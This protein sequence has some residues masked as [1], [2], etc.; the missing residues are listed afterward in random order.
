MS[1]RRIEALVDGLIHLLGSA[2]NPDSELHQIRNC[3]GLMN[4]SRPGKCQIDLKGR[5]VFDSWLASYRASCY[6]IGL[7][8][9]GESRAGLKPTDTLSS[10]LGVFNIKEKLGQKQV[11]NYLRRSLKNPDISVD[12]PLSYFVEE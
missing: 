5:R 2:S 3:I 6:D 10:L 7:K 11:I 9:S 8:C 1:E 4:F 12:T